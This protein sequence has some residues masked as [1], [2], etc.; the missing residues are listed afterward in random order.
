MLRVALE[1][2]REIRAPD[3]G[4]PRSAL[5]PDGAAPRYTSRT[6]LETA[7]AKRVPGKPFR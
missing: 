7:A 2:V 1:K 4:T 6:A 3:A 5:K